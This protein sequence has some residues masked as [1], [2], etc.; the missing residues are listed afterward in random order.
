MKQNRI[1]AY[2]LYDGIIPAMRIQGHTLQAIGDKC[3][4]SRERIRQILREHYPNQLHPTLLTRKQLA[5]ILQCSPSLLQTIEAE[6][7][8]PS[9]HRDHRFFY[10]PKDIE[11]IKAIV[12]SKQPI[13]EVQLICEVCGKT[14]YRKP[15]YIRPT[16][17]PGRFCSNKCKS[18]FLGVHYGF[19]IHPE[20][21]GRHRKYDY[22]LIYDLRDKTGWDT[23]KISRQLHIPLG[24]V[25][26]ILKKRGKP[27]I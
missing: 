14:F 23:L 27:A 9:I 15:Y 6:G 8:S 26:T 11:A 2:S 18:S 1:G 22:Q 12:E 19:G 4:V 13:P 16:Q 3:G 24:T 17:S 10:D 7:L 25:D 5:Q 20:H 21:A